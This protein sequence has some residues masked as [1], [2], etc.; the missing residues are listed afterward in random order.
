MDAPGVHSNA[1]TEE[2]DEQRAARLQA[3]FVETDAHL[4]DVPRKSW[5]KDDPIV[6]KFLRKGLI[7]SD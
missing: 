6:E 4:A 3:L 7:D 1:R 5:P 2:S